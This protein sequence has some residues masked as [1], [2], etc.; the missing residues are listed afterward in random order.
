V[1]SVTWYLAVTDEDSASTTVQGHWVL[2]W[3]WPGGAVGR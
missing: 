2:L 1:I 3:K